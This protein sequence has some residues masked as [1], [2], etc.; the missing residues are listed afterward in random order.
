MTLVI[1]TKATKNKS[2]LLFQHIVV[3]EREFACAF[4][5]VYKKRLNTAL[6][7][8]TEMCNKA[9]WCTKTVRM[10]LFICI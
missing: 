7:S 5:R 2:L 10:S 9:Q 3:S 4:S 8:S 6:I 1:I